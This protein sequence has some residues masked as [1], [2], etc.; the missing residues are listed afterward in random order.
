MLKVGVLMGSK[1]LQKSV[2][3]VNLVHAVKLNVSIRQI[4]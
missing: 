1:T 4:I 2:F 3:A